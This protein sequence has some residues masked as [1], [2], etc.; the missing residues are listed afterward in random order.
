M[1]R[2]FNDIISFFARYYWDEV[3]STF[4]ESLIIL[5]ISLFFANFEHIYTL[6]DPSAQTV[7]NGYPGLMPIFKI[8]EW[9]ALVSTVTA[10]AAGSIKLVNKFRSRR[11]GL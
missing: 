10:L 1:N 3:G 6:Y 2:A 9:P 7:P 8:I 5:L 11:A 4:I